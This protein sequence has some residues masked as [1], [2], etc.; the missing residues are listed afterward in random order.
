MFHMKEQILSHT[1]SE[2]LKNNT[3]LFFICKIQLKSNIDTPIK[4]IICLIINHN[5]H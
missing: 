3:D 1:C 4:E 2:A 5:H